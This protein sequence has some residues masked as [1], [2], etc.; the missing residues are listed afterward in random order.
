MRSPETDKHQRVI[1]NHCVNRC[2][3]DDQ[4]VALLDFQIIKY[5]LMGL[6]KYFDT[7]IYILI[8]K[9]DDWNEISC[10]ITN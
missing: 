3:I 8:N 4:L 5:R 6:P 7:V 10:E 2:L 9:H 1:S